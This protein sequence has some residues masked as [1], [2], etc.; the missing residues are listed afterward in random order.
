MLKSRAVPG[1]RISNFLLSL[2]VA[3]V[4]TKR[5]FSRFRLPPTY[6]LSVTGVGGKP[7]DAYPSLLIVRWGLLIG[8]MVTSFNAESV[9]HTRLKSP[10]VLAFVL[11]AHCLSSVTEGF[12]TVMTSLSLISSRDLAADVP[13]PTFLLAFIVNDVES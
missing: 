11:M 13:I 9:P 7:K 5:V 2:A 8:D 10:A 3:G 12:H 4:E 6:N 1:E